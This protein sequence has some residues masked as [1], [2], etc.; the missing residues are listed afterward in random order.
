MDFL[1]LF[2]LPSLLLPVSFSLKV[3][4]DFL[5]VVGS[6][7]GAATVETR[8]ASNFPDSPELSA[9]IILELRSLSTILLFFS[10]DM[11]LI[12]CEILVQT[13]NA[14]SQISLP[15]NVPSGPVHCLIWAK[16][17]FYSLSIIIGRRRAT[18]YFGCYGEKM[19]Q[20]VKNP[21]VI[22]GTQTNFHQMT[23]LLLILISLLYCFWLLKELDLA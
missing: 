19:R 14:W 17:S 3:F 9:R 23:T 7:K 8:K 6:C 10:A 20:K 5:G 18:L 2:F 4:V 16:L 21:G 11:V 1:L 13:A 15:V 12:G 22:P